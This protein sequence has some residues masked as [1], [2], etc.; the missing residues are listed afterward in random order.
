MLCAVFS[1]VLL[2]YCRFWKRG[3]CYSLN[4]F[5]SSI[6]MALGAVCVNSSLCNPGFLELSFD[7]KC[8]FAD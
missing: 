3:S 2:V 1:S 5:C 7:C 6:F 8:S 4:M